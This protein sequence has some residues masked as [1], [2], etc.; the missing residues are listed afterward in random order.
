MLSLEDF[1]NSW[2]LNLVLQAPSTLT[3]RDLKIRFA[4][5]KHIKHFPSTPVLERQQSPAICFSS[6]KFRQ[7]GSWLSWCDD[8]WKA[9]FSKCIPSTLKG[10]QSLLALRVFSTSSVLATNRP[11]VWMEPRCVK[12]KSYCFNKSRGQKQFDEPLKI[13]CSC[14]CEQVMLVF[15]FASNWLTKLWKSFSIVSFSIIFQHLSKNRCIIHFGCLWRCFSCC[16]GAETLWNIESQQSGS[17][18]LFLTVW[19]R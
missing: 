1:Q 4:L 12:S 3:W 9:L 7:E 17:F 14:M 6:G 11:L 2:K 18:G 16:C 15:F 5:W 10:L 8:F 13:S 19:V